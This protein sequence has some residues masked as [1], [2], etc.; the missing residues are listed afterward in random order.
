[1]RQTPDVVDVLFAASAVKIVPAVLP[2]HQRYYRLLGV[3]HEVWDDMLLVR[4]YGQVPMPALGFALA[5]K[6][7]VLE[8]AR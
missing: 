3:A 7:A 8:F 2:V 4:V 5:R 1:M 6:N